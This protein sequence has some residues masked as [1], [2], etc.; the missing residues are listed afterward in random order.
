ACQFLGDQWFLEKLAKDNGLA[1][2][3]QHGPWNYTQGQFLP[4]GAA[5]WKQVT[6]TNTAKNTKV[7]FDQLT[8]KGA[9]HFVP[10]DR[11]GPALQMIYN[12]VNQLDYNRNLT[13]DYS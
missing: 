1:V 8:V 9:G 3:R 2:T 7:V 11:P 6:Y 12:F 13:L 4:R 5:Y 10:Q